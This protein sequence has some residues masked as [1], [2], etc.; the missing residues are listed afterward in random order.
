MGHQQDGREPRHYDELGVAPSAS[1]ADIRA[2]YVALARRHHPDRMGASSEQARA[3]AAVRMARVNAAWT[4]LSD[5]ARRAAYDA[6]LAGPSTTAGGAHVRDPDSS[7]QPF[8]TS[9]DIDPRLF[10]DTPTGAPSI[11]RAFALAPATLAAVGVTMIL[12]GAFL[13]YGGMLIA[14]FFVLALAGLSFLAL[15]FVA[16]IN[17][18][19]NDRE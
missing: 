19:R 15:P 17:A 7:F 14:G 11:P 5:P 1:P 4:V 13:G 10:D 2:A 8:D 12:G 18:S 3:D 6:R 16:L 9:D